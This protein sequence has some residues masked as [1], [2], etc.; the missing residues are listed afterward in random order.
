MT[1]IAA[2][3]GEGVVWIASDTKITDGDTKDRIYGKAW[4]GKDGIAF[5]GAGVWR[6]CQVL[7]HGTRIPKRLKGQDP[8]QWLVTKLTRAI[9]NGQDEA[10]LTEQDRQISILV[11]MDGR[12]YHIDTS[13]SVTPCPRGYHAIGSGANVAL[14][15]LYSSTG[16]APRARVSMAVKAAC[17]HDAGCALPIELLSVGDGDA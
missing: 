4:I 10:E 14:G 6:A 5:A 7:R 13:M 8:M 2:V 3:E 9:T 15:S 12:I 16:K 17:E 11:V 1:C